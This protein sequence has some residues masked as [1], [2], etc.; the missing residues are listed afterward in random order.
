MVEKLD[1][2]CRSVLSEYE[3]TGNEKDR[4]LLNS[5]Y[6]CDYISCSSK[7]EL[8]LLP[9]DHFPKIYIYCGVTGTYRSLG[10]S[11][12]N[13]PCCK[14]C[15]EKPEVQRKKRKTM[16]QSDFVKKKKK[17]GR[18]LNSLMLNTYILKSIHRFEDTKY[19]FSQNKKFLPTRKCISGKT[20][21]F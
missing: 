14:S 18:T 7:I 21:Y 13:Y 6:V 20:R 17:R 9:V 2:V 12:E 8:P 1:F 3:G 19:I 5:I 4:K 15:K 10:K 11:L 16:I